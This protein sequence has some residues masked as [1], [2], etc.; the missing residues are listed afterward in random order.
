MNDSIAEV[1]D[2][3]STWA[4]VQADCRQVVLPKPA[5]IMADPP[6]GISHPCAFGARGRSKLAQA[7]DFAD[8]RGDSE[9]FDPTFLLE[10]DCP[11]VLWGANHFADKLPSSGG[12]LVWD[13]E[14][15]DDLDQATCELA[16][17]NFVKGV[18]R[19]R[20]LWH[21]MMRAGQHGPLVHPTEKPVALSEW[22]LSLR[23]AP[24]PEAG[25]VLDPFAGSFSTGVACVRNG[26]SFVGIESE[27]A[28]CE[29]GR[30]RLAEAAAQGMLFAPAARKVRDDAADL[31]L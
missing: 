4:V 11:T 12:W 7:R 2:G 13:K 26:R 31:L 14:R 20:Y 21:G 28:Y 1:L 24:A 18:R 5:L 17:T 3:T 10:L 23:W 15:P 16:W 19:F 29:I 22:V 25:I 30:R 9:P 27:A 6:Y 8:V